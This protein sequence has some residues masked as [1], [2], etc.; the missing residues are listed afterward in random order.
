M[1]ELGDA[2]LPA[3]LP[4]VER[5]RQQTWTAEERRW[6][7][8]RRGRY[9]EFNLV[10]DRG[11]IFGLKTDGRIESILMSLPTEARWEYAHEPDPGQPGGGAMEAAAAGRSEQSGRTPS[12]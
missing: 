9:V 8:I 3:Y 11:T 12:V 1:R 10:Y 2:F 7:L 6:Q 4:I 5:R